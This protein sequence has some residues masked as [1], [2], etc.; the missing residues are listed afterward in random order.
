MIQVELRC[1]ERA[2]TAIA[3]AD[4]SIAVKYA[5]EKVLFF[6]CLVC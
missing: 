4:K 5:T 3:K 1:D 6:V 2:R